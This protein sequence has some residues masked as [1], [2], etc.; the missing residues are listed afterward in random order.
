LSFCHKGNNIVTAEG[1]SLSEFDA[2]IENNDG[3]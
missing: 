3:G 1:F 2:K